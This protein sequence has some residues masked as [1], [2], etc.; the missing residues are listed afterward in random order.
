MFVDWYLKSS[1]AISLKE[2]SPEIKSARSIKLEGFT[3]AGI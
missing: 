1:N 3:Y 2:S